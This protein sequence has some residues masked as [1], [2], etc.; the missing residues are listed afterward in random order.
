MELV[1]VKW[2]DSLGNT[3]IAGPMPKREYGDFKLRVM[4]KGGIVYDD[5]AKVYNI[6]LGGN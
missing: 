2:K 3:W 1:T 6:P 5:T 4:N